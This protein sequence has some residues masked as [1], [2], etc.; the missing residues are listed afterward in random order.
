[1]DLK[2]FIKGVLADITSAISESQSELNN[3]A[4]IS[5]CRNQS[6]GDKIIHCNNKSTIVSDV[7]FEVA[8][9][10]EDSK[11]SSKGI[12]GGIKVISGDL[13]N[14]QS[15][16]NENISR[17]KFSIPVVYPSVSDSSP[18]RSPPTRKDLA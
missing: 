12:G 18:K 13:S 16:K 2:N 1:M 11:E 9:T 3:G 7:D 4:V 14:C 17:I 10:T 15:E 8:L 6:N 5:P